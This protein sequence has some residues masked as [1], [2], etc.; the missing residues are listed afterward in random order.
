MPQKTNLQKAIDAAW[1]ARRDT[2]GTRRACNP[3]TE[4]RAGAAAGAAAIMATH[5]LLLPAPTQTTPALAEA[6]RS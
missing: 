5:D 3:E 2:R 1:T 4:F 6:V